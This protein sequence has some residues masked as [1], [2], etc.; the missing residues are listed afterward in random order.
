MAVD[1]EGN[2]YVGGRTDEALPGQLSSGQIDA[3]LMKF[4][5]SGKELWTRQFGSPA[6][7]WVM[8]LAV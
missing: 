6:D 3:F 1:G 5:G 2:I 8:G 7:D 4:D